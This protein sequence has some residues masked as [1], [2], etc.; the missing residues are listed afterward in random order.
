MAPILSLVASKFDTIRRVEGAEPDTQALLASIVM[1]SHDAIVSMT[2]DRWILSWNHGAEILY[3]YR[4]DEMVG[5]SVDV[6][7]PAD[8][9]PDEREIIALVAHGARLERFRTRRIRKDGTVISVSL[10]VSPLTDAGGQIIGVAWTA[11]DF[12]ERERAQARFQAVLEAAPD[13][14]VGIDRAGD[15][16]LANTQTQRMFGYARHELTGRPVHQLVAKGLPDDLWF[17]QENGRV[18]PPPDGEPAVA[19]RKDGGSFPVE[20]TVSGLETDDGAVVC[21][22][23]RDISERVA[24]Q[25]EAD[26][27]RAEAEAERLA[28]RVQRTQRLESLGQLAGGVA[29]DFNNLLAVILNYGTFVIDE[30]NEP[31]PNLEAIARDGEQIVRAAKR[32]TDLTHQLLAF[33]RREVVRPRVLDL[34]QAITDVQDMLRRAIG[35]HIELVTQL[36]DGLPRVTADAG[37]IEQVLV[38]LAVNARDAMPGGGRLTI[39]T[40]LAD[41]DAGRPGV[42]PGRYVRVRV[43]D[44]GS[45]MT[46]EVIDRAFEPFYTTKRS[47]EGTGLGLATVYGIVTQAKGAVHLYSEPGIGTTVTVLLPATDEPTAVVS[48]P[49]A[50]PAPESSGTG[51][52]VLVVEDEPALRDLACRILDGAGYHVLSASNGQDALGLAE[53]YAGRIELLLTDVIMPGMLGKELADRMLARDP[54]LRVLFMSGYAQPVL[55]SRGTLDP[56]VT[57]IEKPFAKAELLSA[58]RHRLDRPATP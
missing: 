43:S 41:L 52:V 19:R 47:G 55:A 14:I 25:A 27:L 8:R 15:I 54:T 28:A 21:L 37:Q 42:E 30:A 3:D 4:A 29:H 50:D 6:L 11:R 7:V 2:L 26:R 48:V 40:A 46:K 57:L 32:G 36:A 56:G 13:A 38:N 35:E 20:M 17:A 53:G 16:V 39:E 51:E 44:S 45:G 49:A 18:V 34:N 24:A 5:R 9:W 23:I 1:S 58:I 33:A 12:S 10:A 22:A 31:D